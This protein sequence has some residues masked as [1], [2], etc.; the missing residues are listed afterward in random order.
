VAIKGPVTTPIGSGFRSV[1]VALRKELDP[2][3]QPATRG[4]HP[5]GEISLRGVDL[6]RGYARTREDLY[7]GV[8]HMVGPD[9][10]ESIKIITRRGSERIARFAFDYA[11]RRD[12]AGTRRFTK[13]TS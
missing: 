5:W 11:R 4:Q 9:A 7:A 1:N 2:V 13:P 12:A 3:R 6:G 8:E 10:A